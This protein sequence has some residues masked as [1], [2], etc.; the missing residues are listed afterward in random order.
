MCTYIFLLD[1]EDGHPG[2]QGPPGPPGPPGQPGPTGCRKIYLKLTKFLGQRGPPGEP[3]ISIPGE[4][5]PP[6]PPGQPG[7]PVIFFDLEILLNLK[8]FKRDLPVHLESQ[9]R[10]FIFIKLF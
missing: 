8:F 4:K 6:G 2:I 3:G 10:Y 7:R 1:G 9:D 5:P